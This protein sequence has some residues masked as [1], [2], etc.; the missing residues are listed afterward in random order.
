MRCAWTVYS[1]ASNRNWESSICL[2][3]IPSESAENSGRLNDQAPSYPTA[4]ILPT[5][6]PPI[7]ESVTPEDHARPVGVLRPDVDH[8]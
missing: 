4:P 3:T 7:E 1:S 5:N 2:G 6:T 8:K